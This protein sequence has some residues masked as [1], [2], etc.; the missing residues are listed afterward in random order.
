VVHP[1]PVTCVAFAPDGGTAATAT[2]GGTVAV[3]DV[4]RRE[5]RLAL[6]MA[7]HP[8]LGAAAPL[9]ALDSALLAAIANLVIA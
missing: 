5:D 9:A 4:L 7:R 2:A 1:W 3:W 8:R 6:A